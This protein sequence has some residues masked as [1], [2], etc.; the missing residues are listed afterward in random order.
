MPLLTLRAGNLSSMR[1]PLIA[2]L[3]TLGFLC[4]AFLGNA[5]TTR[6]GVQ[7]PT[8]AVQTMSVRDCCGRLTIRA[9]RPGESGFKQCRCQEKRQGAL[10]ADAVPRNDALPPVPLRLEPRPP[11]PWPWTEYA[12]LGRTAAWSAPPALRPPTLS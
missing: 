7:C 11:L 1:S 9:P 8:A 5:P 3:A 2:I 12:Y 6:A 4:A 10:W